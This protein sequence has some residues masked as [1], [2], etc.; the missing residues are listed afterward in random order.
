MSLT[1]TN[2]KGAKSYTLEPKG[3]NCSVMG[4]NRAGKSTLA[5]A[6]SFLLFNKNDSGQSAQAF[7][8]KPRDKAGNEIHNLDT[9]VSAVFKLEDGETLT[10]EKTTKENW[11]KKHGQK[12]QEFSG[13]TTTYSIDGVPKTQSQ[14]DQYISGICDEKRFRALTNVRYV[15]EQIKWDERRKLLLSLFG[16]ISDADVI[17]GNPELSPLSAILGK[18]SVE[19]HK[20]TLTKDRKATQAE[21][22]EIRPRIDEQNRTITQAEENTPE[23]DSVG[24]TVGK[25]DLAGLRANLSAAQQ[26]KAQVSSG[27]QVAE[28]LVELRNLEGEGVRLQNELLKAVN[29]EFDEI[30]KV[31]RQAKYVLDGEKLKAQGL[32]REIQSNRTVIVTLE[33]S[34]KNLRAEAIRI[35]GTQ[36]DLSRAVADSC[37]ACNRP[38]DPDKVEAAKTKALEDFNLKKSGLLETNMTIGKK[39]VADLA[40]YKAVVAEKE[41]ELATLE[42]SIASLTEQ[43]EEANEQ[44]NEAAPTAMGSPE[45]IANINAQTELKTRIESM[46]EEGSGALASVDEQI[47]AIESDIAKAEAYAAALGAV[48][49][50]RDRIVELEK[51]EKRLAGEVDRM[52][53][54]LYLCEQFIRAK[55]ERL[56]EHINKQFALTKWRLF[57]TQINGA[58]AEC[59]EATIDGRGYSSALSN[60]ERIRVGLDICETLGRSYKFHP[61][62][63]VDNAESIHDLPPTTAQQIR[64]IVSATD[65]KL[66]V[67]LDEPKAQGALIG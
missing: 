23:V 11:V 66:R 62:V 37:P 41:A 49:K 56:T 61:V 20:I 45:S 24:P 29:A 50:A 33:D 4:A 55:C 38:L 47:E 12:D 27:G 31:V 39:A 19:D 58:I 36:L 8:W 32:E 57:E 7:D 54:E 3:A 35:K 44:A 63:V 9:T 10:L 18:R 25:P 21:L 13:H 51:E 59:C 48:Q 6:I 28:L 14:Y 5:D 30:N 26:R 17:A 67:V 60:S 43:Y 15:C 16:D 40:I 53:N 42:A 64:L 1:L 2:F 22:K 34:L 52:E 46:R 65:K